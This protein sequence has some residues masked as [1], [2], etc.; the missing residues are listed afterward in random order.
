M[1][2][3]TANLEGKTWKAVQNFS[4]EIPIDLLGLH[5]NYLKWPKITLKPNN[6]QQF[7]PFTSIS[8]GAHGSLL[9]PIT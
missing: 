5:D 8:G 9:G 7:L 3:A 1:G 2:A 6:F 4:L